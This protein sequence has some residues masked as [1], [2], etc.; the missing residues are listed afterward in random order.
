[1][2][3][4]RRARRSRPAV[5]IA[6]AASVFAFLLVA[7]ATGSLEALELPWYDLQ[8]QR[9]SRAPINPPPIAL[10]LIQEDDIRRFGHPLPDDLLRQLLERLLAAEP[11]AIGVDLYRDQPVPL[12]DGDPQLDTPAYR[13]LGAVVKGDPRIVMTMKFPDPGRPGTPPPRFLSGQGQVGFSDLPVDRGGIIR[14]GLLFLWDGDRPL[15]S[16]ALQLALRY[17]SVERIALEPDP[18]DTERVKLGPTVIPPFRADQGPY[19]GA[20]D[21]GYQF[22]LDYRWGERSIDTY[23]LTSLLA[24]EVEPGLLRDRIVLVGTAAPSVK[25]SFF[26]PIPRGQVSSDPSMYGVEVHAQAAHQLLRY[27][28]GESRPLTSY[29]SGAVAGWVAFWC[30]AGAGVGS[31]NRRLFVLFGALAVAVAVLVGTGWMLFERSTWVPVMTPLVGLLGSMAGVVAASSVL[32]RAARRQLLGLFSRFQGQ[33]VV[34]EIWRRRDEFI[35]EGGRPVTQ[36]LVLTALLADLE[37][38]TGV[39]ERLRYFDE[40]RE[41]G[42]RHHG[43]LWRSYAPRHEPNGTASYGR[44]TRRMDEHQ[45]GFTHDALEDLSYAGLPKARHAERT[46]DGYASRRCYDVWSWNSICCYSTQRPDLRS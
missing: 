8:L 30:L 7:R 6:V 9:A 27:A 3:Y 42:P 36:R 4:W 31:W 10:V 21:A 17:L 43:Q 32:E 1:M 13:E 39:S 34:D 25:D 22:L 33:D 45:L 18:G 19:V 37:G 46:D 15:L 2:D 14:R 16:F 24:G 11:R 20:D 12:A 41:M 40:L 23:R 28:S 5:A 26:T 38:Y 44:G 29:G 35:G